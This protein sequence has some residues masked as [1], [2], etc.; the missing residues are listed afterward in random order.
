MQPRK[1]ER[2]RDARDQTRG[3]RPERNGGPRKNGNERKA[4]YSHQRQPPERQ[5]EGPGKSEE[6]GVEEALC[7]RQLVEWDRGR[8]SDHSQ[9]RGHGLGAPRCATHH[10]KQPCQYQDKGDP[11]RPIVP[12]GSRPHFPIRAFENH[13]QQGDVVEREIPDGVSHARVILGNSNALP[14][15]PVERRRQVV[16]VGAQPLR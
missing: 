13:A 3:P 5:R 15:F 8:H 10:E 1:K 12:N 7:H 6:R 4:C 16:H 14:G 9:G 11:C 2:K